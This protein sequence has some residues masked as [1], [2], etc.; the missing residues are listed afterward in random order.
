[1]AG[2][3]VLGNLLLPTENISLA[4]SLVPTVLLSERMAK[5]PDFVRQVALVCQSR[6]RSPSLSIQDNRLSCAAAAASL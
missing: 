2:Y 5:Y 3:L 4:V 1:M 6:H